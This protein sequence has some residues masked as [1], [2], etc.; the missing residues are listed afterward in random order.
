MESHGS[1]AFKS[2]TSVS[3]PNFQEELSLS[4]Y[5]PLPDLSCYDPV[6]G[7]VETLRVN[8]VKVVNSMDKSQLLFPAKAEELSQLSNEPNH[9]IQSRTKIEK[10]TTFIA[11]LLSCP[12]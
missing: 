12:N 3:Y 8:K 1:G 6:V 11:S 4:R 10:S 5:G 9:R 2:S 7:V